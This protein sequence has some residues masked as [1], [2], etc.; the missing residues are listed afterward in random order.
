MIVFMHNQVLLSNSIILSD[1]A[2][3]GVFFTQNQVVMATSEY[4]LGCCIFRWYRN[5]AKSGGF[6]VYVLQYQVVALP[7]GFLPI[8]CSSRWFL[9]KKPPGTAKIF[10]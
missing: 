2:K 7:G 9:A 3:T 1:D 6:L 8:F 10:P 4:C 5:C